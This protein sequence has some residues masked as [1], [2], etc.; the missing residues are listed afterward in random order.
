M[1]QPKRTAEEMFPLAERYNER[2]QSA[3]AFCAE[4]GISYGQLNYWR[5]KYRQETP[6]EDSQGFVEVGNTAPAARVEI[7]YPHERM[8]L[9]TS[10]QTP[11]LP[12]RNSRDIPT[13]MPA[14]VDQN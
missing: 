7:A 14:K 13:A 8:A 10:S 2:T 1:V 3:A 12:G 11:Y 6:A 5:R 4:H 9:F